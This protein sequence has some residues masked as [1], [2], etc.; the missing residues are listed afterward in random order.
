MKVPIRYTLAKG[1]L[2]LED[3]HSLPR[4]LY[5]NK[6]FW[7]SLPPMTMVWASLVTLPSLQSPPL[8]F[9]Q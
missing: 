3:S 8:C 7:H 5:Q 9:Q 1:I 6:S 4:L 2:V